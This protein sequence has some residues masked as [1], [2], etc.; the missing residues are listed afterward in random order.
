M[1]YLQK[2]HLHVLEKRLTNQT[3]ARNFRFSGEV[4][5]SR[6]L[7]RVGKRGRQDRK[8][9]M[10]CSMFSCLARTKNKYFRNHIIAW[11]S[12]HMGRQDLHCTPRTC[13]CQ[14]ERYLYPLRQ[15][16][17]EIFAV[18]SFLKQEGG[19]SLIW[20]FLT[21]SHFLLTPMSLWSGGCVA[22]AQKKRIAMAL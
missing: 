11:D 7:A 5:T 19:T 2:C 14:L 3:K 9:N 18:C 16:L 4:G 1:N 6:G 12:T 21:G 20:F 17:S 8:K 13:N 15:S 22:I 10:R